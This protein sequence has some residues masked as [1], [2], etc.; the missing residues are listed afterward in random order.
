[1]ARDTDEGPRENLG[2]RAGRRRLA[3]VMDSDLWTLFPVE[4]PAERSGRRG[5]GGGSR[6]PRAY[7][8]AAADRRVKI[9]PFN[10]VR[11]GAD[12]GW[13]LGGTD[14]QPDLISVH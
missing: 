6:R 1:M 14:H 9:K 3:A 8:T 12:D 10:N 13:L 7:F 11:G 5:V 4:P 2:R